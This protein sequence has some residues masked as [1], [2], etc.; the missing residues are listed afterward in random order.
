MP[1]L[2]ATGLVILLV[3]Y[4]W[5]VLKREMARIGDEM[6]QQREPEKQKTGGALEKGPDG[7]YR[8]KRTD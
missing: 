3:F 1:Q 4:A 5:R 7:V 6:D 8:P 2:I